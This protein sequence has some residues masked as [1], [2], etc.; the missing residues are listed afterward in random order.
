MNREFLYEMIATP[1]VSGGEFALQ[2]KV[3]AYMR[4]R[5]AEVSTDWT[6]NVIAS[7]NPESPLQVLLCGHIDEIGYRVTHITDEGYLH[8]GKAGGVRLAL[9]QGQRVTVQGKRPVNGVMGLLLDKGEVKTGVEITDLYVDCGFSSREDALRLVSPGDFV[10]YA[11]GVDELENGCIAGRGLDNRLGAY[12][13]LHALLRARELGAKAGIHAAATVG[14][15][16]TQRGAYAAASRLKPSLCV[17]VDVIHT[18]DFSG[19]LPQ[20]FGKIA[21]NGGPVICRSALCSEPINRA[22]EDAARRLEMPVQC[23]VASGVTG[24]DADTAIKAW[25]SV[26]ATVLSIPLRYMHAPSE[27]G[28]LTDVEQTVELLAEFLRGLDEH[29][30]A[31]PFAL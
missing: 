27:V 6:G 1:S 17:A 26:P 3:A 20:R 23:E 24:T 8:L 14:E 11:C 31:D 25:Q 28:S 4:E 19:S 30:T 15:E 10:T 21:L 2:R 13:V 12:T 16:T 18:S 9:A 29:F 7:I 5:G 22:L